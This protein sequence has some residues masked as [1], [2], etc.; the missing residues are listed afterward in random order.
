METFKKPRIKNKLLIKK[1][2]SYYLKKNLP[3][4]K[5]GDSIKLNIKIKEGEKTRLQAY[6]GIIISKKN[7]DINK[8]ITVRRII[9]GIGIER[10]FLLNSPKIET[11]EIQKSSKIRRS[12]LYYL[13]NLAGKATRLKQIFKIN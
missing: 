4:I 3:V 9:Q 12:K 7:T 6:E 2:E 10:S 11:I 1:I 13:K 8:T 5:T